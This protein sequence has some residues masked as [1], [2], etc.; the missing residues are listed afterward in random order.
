MDI[1]A[2]LY[3]PPIHSVEHANPQRRTCYD[4]K[5]NQLH[6]KTFILP[7]TRL[8]YVLLSTFTIQISTSQS[9]LQLIKV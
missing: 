4:K 2:Q 1:L 5:L 8:F 7:L 6:N 3:T 9:Q